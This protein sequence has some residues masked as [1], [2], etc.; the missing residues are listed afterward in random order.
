MLQNLIYNPHIIAHNYHYYISYK[1]HHV[2]LHT[3]NQRVE[4]S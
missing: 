4:L 3:A 1:L 2:S